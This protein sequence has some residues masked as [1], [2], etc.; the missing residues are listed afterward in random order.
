MEMQITEKERKLII[1]ALTRQIRLNN[2]TAELVS[3]YEVCE[4]I[5]EKNKELNNLI[6]KLA[7]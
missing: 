4:M 6:K 7:L 1:K 3:H 5:E 2:N